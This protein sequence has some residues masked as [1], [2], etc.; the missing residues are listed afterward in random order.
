MIF[1]ENGPNDND[2]DLFSLEYDE[3]EYTEEE[4]N[5]YIQEHD[6]R[7]ENIDYFGMLLKEILPALEIQELNPGDY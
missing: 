1:R 7:I 2:N 4:I 6:G 3:E 5:S